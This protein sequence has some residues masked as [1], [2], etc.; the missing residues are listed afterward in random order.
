MRGS[1]GGFGDKKIKGKTHIQTT[2]GEKTPAVSN[3]K[4]PVF[5]QVTCTR[6]EAV[7]EGKRTH[8][9]G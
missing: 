7:A 6:K 1:V 9:I 4:L 2:M 3:M 5:L 8:T